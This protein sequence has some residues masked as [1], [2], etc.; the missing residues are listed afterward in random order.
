MR[1]LEKLTIR[2]FKSIREQTLEFGRLNIFIGANGAGK[3]NLLQVFRFLREIQQR[4]LATYSLQRG[5]DSLLYFG[6]KISQSME[7]ILE[8]SEDDVR[9]THS[10]RLVPT[11]EGAFVVEYQLFAVDDPKRAAAPSVESWGGGGVQRLPLM[12][13]K[14]STG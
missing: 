13:A 11:D 6:R 2:N 10:L 4:N 12:A 8:F 9:K 7:F 5:A 14:S 3:S 1:T